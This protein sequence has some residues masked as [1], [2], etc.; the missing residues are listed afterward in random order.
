MEMLNSHPAI[1]GYG[2]LLT[3]APATRYPQ[4]R[5]ALYSDP[6]GIPFFAAYLGDQS[7]AARLLTA[8]R[9]GTR[10]LAQVYAPQGDLRAIGF[11]LL[12]GHLR[13]RW[14][15]PVPAATWL[16]PYLALKDVR[17]VHLVRRN[18]LDLLV[19]RK[20]AA[21]RH[22]L[23]ARPGDDVPATSVH[24]PTASLLPELDREERKDASV[25]RMLRLLRVPV[26]QVAYE[27]LMADTAA[28]YGRLLTFLAAVPLDHQPDWRMQKVVGTPL[29]ETIDNY[30]EVVRALRPTRHASFVS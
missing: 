11:R 22:V 16:L 5:A 3:A 9:L 7:S 10:Y 4:T 23:H 25:R 26:L 30:A 21:A 17:V 1:G 12:Y 27:D 19:S 18:K 28:E 20:V 6:G 8:P 13:Q 24:V 14:N 29:A 15:T 2:E